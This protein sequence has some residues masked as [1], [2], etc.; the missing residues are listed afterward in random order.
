MQYV[1][2]TPVHEALRNTFKKLADFPGGPAVKTPLF[3]CR[4]AQVQSLVGEVLHAARR[5]QNKQTNKLPSHCVLELFLSRTP[6]QTPTLIPTPT[7]DSKNT[8]QDEAKPS[9][10]HFTG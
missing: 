8:A 5:G 4:G 7:P 6:S 9:T 1:T 3:Q 2:Y 10:A